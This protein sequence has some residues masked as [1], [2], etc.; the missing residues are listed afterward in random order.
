MLV[1]GEGDCPGRVGKRDQARCRYRGP[2]SRGSPTS[3]VSKRLARGLPA[4][5]ACSEQNKLGVGEVV[6]PGLSA[7]H[8]MAVIKT[9]EVSLRGRF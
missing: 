6:V 3:S 9:A 5:V 8:T 7:S 2:G 4:S 1:G